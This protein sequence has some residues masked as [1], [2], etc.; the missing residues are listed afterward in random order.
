MSAG[1]TSQNEEN[2]C[3]TRTPR[4]LSDMQCYPRKRPFHYS[5]AR[6]PWFESRCVHQSFLSSTKGFFGFSN[7]AIRCAPDRHGPIGG[8]IDCL[9]GQ[10]TTSRQRPAPK[11]GNREAHNPG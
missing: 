4:V 5:H 2:P 6:G 10:P 8:P 11:R 7:T 9:G 3:A 1:D